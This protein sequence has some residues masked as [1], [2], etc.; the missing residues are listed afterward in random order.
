MISM[1]IQ[2]F[3]EKRK[4]ELVGFEVVVRSLPNVPIFFGL[5]S[6][7]V[8]RSNGKVELIIPITE[9]TTMTTIFREVGCIE[10]TIPAPSLYMSEYTEGDYD[11]IILRTKYGLIARSR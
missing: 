5:D 9:D 11:V 10:R 6:D 4:Y 7:C 8:S 1:Q 2:K 3:K